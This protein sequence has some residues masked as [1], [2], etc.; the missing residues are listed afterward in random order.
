M[1]QLEVTGS[2]SGELLPR[3]WASL[4]EVQMLGR[5]F[6]EENVT[7]ADRGQSAIRSTP[8]LCQVG[9][10]HLCLHPVLNATVL[11]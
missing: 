10:S 11:R 6:R 9:L 4:E 1:D 7:P 5:T 8:L 2:T 3:R